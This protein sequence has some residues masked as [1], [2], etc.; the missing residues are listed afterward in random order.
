MIG[1]DC[2]VQAGILII[3]GIILFSFGYF[4]GGFIDY[5][6]DFVKKVIK[7]L[8]MS[9]KLFERRITDFIITCIVMIL[10]FLILQKIFIFFNLY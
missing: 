5:I 1:V 10:T 9:S 2:A 6:I 3:V 8:K 4:L 7:I